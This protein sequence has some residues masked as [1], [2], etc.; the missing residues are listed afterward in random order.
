MKELIEKLKTVQGLLV[1]FAAVF[2]VIPS[3][4]NS[5][6]DAYRTIRNIPRGAQQQANHE[7]FQRH[8][9]EQPASSLPM[10]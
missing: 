5:A 10:L 8:F 7:L 9:K 2:V 4:V 6:L 1:A 3:V